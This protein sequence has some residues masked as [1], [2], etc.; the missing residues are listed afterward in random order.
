MRQWTKGKFFCSLMRQVCMQFR[1]AH[2]AVQVVHGQFGCS[3]GSAVISCVLTRGVC[4]QFRCAYTVVQERN[5]EKFR[6][7]KHNSSSQKHA[8]SFIFVGFLLPWQKIHFVPT[9]SLLWTRWKFNC[10]KWKSYFLTDFSF[11]QI[12]VQLHTQK[13]S[14]ACN[15][16]FMCSVFS[17]EHSTHFRSACG[18]SSGAR[19]G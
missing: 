5:S 6:C 11:K 10:N 9:R 2:M 8:R 18:V 13:C 12:K 7:T 3:S 16:Q 1:C 15:R 19:V 4:G 17:S 14:A